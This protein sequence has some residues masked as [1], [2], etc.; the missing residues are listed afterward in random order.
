M[1]APHETADGILGLAA[2]VHVCAALP[3][4]YIAFE[5][6]IGEPDCRYDIVDGLPDP[7]VKDGF[8]DV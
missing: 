4:S 7:L 3:R 6:L 1:V 5:Y 2:F 8:I